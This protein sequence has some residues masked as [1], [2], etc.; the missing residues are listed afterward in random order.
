MA[1]RISLFTHWRL[2]DGSF[3]SVC[4]DCLKKVAAGARESDLDYGERHHMCDEAFGRLL[5]ERRSQSGA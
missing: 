4:P 3:S 1:D 5:N 2:K